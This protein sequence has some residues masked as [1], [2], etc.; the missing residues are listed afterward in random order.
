MQCFKG[1]QKVAGICR[2]R[3]KMC[4]I[5]FSHRQ[6]YIL[7]LHFCATLAGVELVVCGKPGFSAAAAAVTSLKAASSWQELGAGPRGLC[8]E[9]QLQTATDAATRCYIS[10]PGCYGRLDDSSQLQ[11][12]ANC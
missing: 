3:C 6:K 11:G 7:Q 2:N 9:K 10:D 4:A 1:V 8:A 5:F 12:I